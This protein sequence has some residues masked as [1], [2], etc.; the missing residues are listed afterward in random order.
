M[1]MNIDEESGTTVLRHDSKYKPGRSIQ[2]WL[3]GRPLATADAEDQSIGKAI[4]LAVFI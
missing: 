4:G 3:F 1:V 2:T